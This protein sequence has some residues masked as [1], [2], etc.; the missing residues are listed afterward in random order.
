MSRAD[1]RQQCATEPPRR[2]AHHPAVGDRQ[3]RHSSQP[4]ALQHRR[5]GPRP[6]PF[7]HRRCRQIA[8]R[9][10]RQR[11]H[12]VHGRALALVVGGARSIHPLVPLGRRRK[13]LQRHSCVTRW[14]TA[15]LAQHIAPPPSL[16]VRL[17]GRRQE[18]DQV[19]TVRSIAQTR[20]M[21]GVRFPR[22]RQSARGRI[23]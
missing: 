11:H 6:G 5:Q 23:R 17:A 12:G 4:M 3:G 9:R 13:R 16:A 2:I 20:T 10:R 15:K 7:L 1:R 8:L 22:R 19:R 14:I 18:G 21:M